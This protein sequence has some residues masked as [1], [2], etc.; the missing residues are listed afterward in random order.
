LRNVSESWNKSK[1]S[2]VTTI[3]SSILKKWSMITHLQTK[4]MMNI[5]K[6]IKRRKIGK[7]RYRGKIALPPGAMTATG[8]LHQ[9]RVKSTT[10]T[11][12]KAIMTARERRSINKGILKLWISIAQLSGLHV[13]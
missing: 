10:A 7:K 5:G 12:M 2:I 4:M 13:V 11:R 8:N 1:I 9:R 3:P 6:K